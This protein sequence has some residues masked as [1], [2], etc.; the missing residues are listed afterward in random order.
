[1]VVYPTVSKRLA[2]G[3]SAPS[4]PV[5]L[6][7]DPLVYD[8]LHAQGTAEDVRGLMRIEELFARGRRGRWLEPACG[9]GRYLR[10]AAKLGVRTSGFDLDE[11]M[12]EFVRTRVPG[13]DVCVSS[14]ESF[15]TDLWRGKFSLAFNL[16][17]TIRHLDHDQAMLEH[18]EQ[19]AGALTP[20]GVYVV[21]LS[22]AHYGHEGSTEDVWTGGRGSLKVTQIVQFEPGSRQERTERV[23]SHLMIERPSGTEH[24]DSAYSL[25][26]YDLKQWERLVS[27]S[28]LRIVA[29][30]DEQGREVQA[31]DGCYRLFVLGKKTN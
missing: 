3:N 12:V 24:R 14:M 20:G 7:S 6:Y 19:M 17:N 5:G 10:R 25:R 16:I 27:K 11:N 9:T 2:N 13:A 15:L 8:I 22:L 4:E 18:F 26:T 21:G 28:A 31:V 29:C 23:Y 30:V 1:V